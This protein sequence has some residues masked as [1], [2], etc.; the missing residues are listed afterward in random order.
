MPQGTPR[1]VSTFGEGPAASRGLAPAAYSIQENGERTSKRRSNVEI[2]SIPGNALKRLRVPGLIDLFE[3][4]DPNEIKALARDPCLDRRFEA[5]TC[6]I[7]WLL[8]KRSLRVL[9]FGGRRFPTMMP[10]D[11]AQRA[12]R[13]QELWSNLSKQADSIKDG[14]GELEALAQWVRGVG[15]DDE[16][17]ILAQ[18]VL[19]RL[20]SGGFV[21]T[22]ASWYAAKVLVA[23]PRSKNLPLM[24]WWF[25][26]GKVRRAKRLL[27]G[28]VNDDLSAVN[29]IGI[30]VH[31]LVKSLRR[32]R[33]LYEDAPARR[34]LS[35][36]AAAEQC[37]FAPVSLFRQASAAGQLGDCPYSR[38]ALFVLAIGEASRS[39]EGRSL[40]FMDDSW[41]RCPANLWVPAMLQGVWRR[42]LMP[43]SLR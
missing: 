30:A 12:S 29:A 35:A 22:E 34:G 11:D 10:R 32:M 16:L 40:V 2:D 36:E 27:A 24:L 26:S 9:S 13:Q 25:L 6:P 28:M 3:V 7:N 42:A 31:N 37:L 41:S 21:A 4:S 23:A 18:Q 14:P 17:G 15:A 20:F 39:A 8:L 1:S 19:G 5:P 38:N 43:A 33:V